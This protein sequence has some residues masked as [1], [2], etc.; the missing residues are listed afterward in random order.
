M[1]IVTDSTASIPPELVEELGIR[2][3]PLDVVIGEER[4]VEGEGDTASR[5]VTALEDGTRVSTSQPAPAAFARAYALASKA[6]AREV[7]SIHLSG[8]LSGTFRAA[9][10]AAL[11]SPVPVHLVDSRSAGLGLGLAVLEAAEAA[12]ERPRRG[13]RGERGERGQRGERG[14]RGLRNPEPEELSGGAGVAQ[15][16][17]D[18]AGSATVLFLVDSLDHLRRGGRLSAGAAALGTVL[19]MRPIL[20]LREGRIE[21]K[22]KVRTR[23]AARDRLVA[24]GVEEAGRR[25]SPRLGVHHLGQPD[26]A[27][28]LATQLALDAGVP[29]SEVMISQISAVIGA[30]AG[31]G[32]LSVVV[33][34][35]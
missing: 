1:A 28:E 22:E 31:P 17:R 14:L 5:L 13:E 29:V 12:R 35:R 21:V 19:G 11:G 30:H 8:E 6:G 18:V 24:L 32:L 3:V 25:A 23:R 26:L 16:A 4:F 15:R 33:T 34:G 10:L 27:A 2:V 7:V 20:T 9:E